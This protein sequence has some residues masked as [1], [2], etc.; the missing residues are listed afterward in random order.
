MQLTR[1]ATERT[2]PAS[3]QSLTGEVLCI[4]IKDIE[5]FDKNPRRS[6]NPAYDR[7]KAS[8]L[9]NG[10]DQPLIVTKRP[11]DE[12]FVVHAGGNTRLQILKELYAVSGDPA[13]AIVNCIFV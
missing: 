3:S 8:I 13:F 2:G 1:P 5:L 4:D 10:L 9:A 12:K 6:R 11:G 7:I